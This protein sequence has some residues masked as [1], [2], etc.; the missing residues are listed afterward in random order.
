MKCPKCH[1]ENPEDTLYCGKCGT[2]LPPFVAETVQTPKEEL[3]TG[4]DFTG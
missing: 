4:S 2:K 1:F 3:T